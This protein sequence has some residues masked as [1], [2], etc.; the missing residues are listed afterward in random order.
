[1]KD[2]IDQAVFALL[3]RFGEFDEEKLREELRQIDEGALLQTGAFV[4]P[5]GQVK[6]HLIGVMEGMLAL[7]MG[8]KTDIA[9]PED[10][11][12]LKEAL[13]LFLK[14]NHTKTYRFRKGDSAKVWA[15]RVLDNLFFELSEHRD[16]NIRDQL[17]M[18]RMSEDPIW[19]AAFSTALDLYLQATKTGMDVLKA[20]DKTAVAVAGKTFK[21]A[22]EQRRA[23]LPKLK[24]GNAL[25][26]L[27]E[28]SEYAVGQ[29]LEGMNVNESLAQTLVKDQLGTGNTGGKGKFEAFLQANKITKDMFPTTVQEL[30]LVVGRSIQFQETEEEISHAVYAFAKDVG[31]ANEVE[32]MFKNFADAVFPVAAKCS[33][34]LSFEG[35]DTAQCG[36]LMADWMKGSELLTKVQ[37][38]GMRQHVEAIMERLAL[39]DIRHLNAFRTGRTESSKIGH[40]ELD[41]YAKMRVRLLTL[42]SVNEK[43]QRVETV[44]GRQMDRT[45]QFISRPGQDLLKDMTFGVEEFFRSL[46]AVFQDVFESADRNRQ[47]QVRTVE[48]FNKKYGPLPTVSILVGRDRRVPIGQWIETARNKMNEV[49]YYVYER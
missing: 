11:G 8:Q 40:A 26:D 10:I 2:D 47:N 3:S 17:V 48:E 37:D 22:L 16:F 36:K 27:R 43:L 14:L 49:P 41:E 23:K 20:A 33:R 44:V 42:N 30:Y 19:R 4:A 34:I 39:N 9:M 13:I 28:I 35:L 29:Y 5:D 1:M 6:I 46:R 24:Y 15:A 45:S 7:A 38:M 32:E 18:L 31:R 21:Q 12:Y 25:A